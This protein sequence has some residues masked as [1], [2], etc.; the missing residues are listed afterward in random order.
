MNK[1]IIVISE[2]VS[3]GVFQQG[4]YDSLLAVPSLLANNPFHV[5]IKYCKRFYSIR[6]VKLLLYQIGLP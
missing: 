5:W 6:S 4:G 2:D 3:S 1:Y